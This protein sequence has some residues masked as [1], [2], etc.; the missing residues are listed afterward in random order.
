MND[1]DSRIADTILAKLH[2]RDPALGPEDLARPVDDF[3]FDSLDLVELHQ[4][5]ESALQVRGDLTETAGFLFLDEF[6]TYF[7]KL[8]GR[9]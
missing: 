7:R 3:D 2:E 5:L 9:E 8:A 4:R 6:S 1:I